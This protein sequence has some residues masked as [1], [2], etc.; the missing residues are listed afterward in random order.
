M[1]YFFKLF[2][3]TVSF[4]FLTGSFLMFNLYLLDFSMLESY[5]SIFNDSVESLNESVFED[6][7][8]LDEKVVNT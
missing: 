5:L 1:I 3:D 8:L 2:F 6:T 7:V 4:F